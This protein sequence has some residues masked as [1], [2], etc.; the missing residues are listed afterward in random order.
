MRSSGRPALPS[1]PQGFPGGIPGGRPD[2][3]DAATR[4]GQYL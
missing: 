3:R 2:E 4:P 1:G